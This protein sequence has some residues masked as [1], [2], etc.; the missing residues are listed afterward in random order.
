MRWVRRIW[1]EQPFPAPSASDN[2]GPRPAHYQFVPGPCGA[3][4]APEQSLQCRPAGC[5][6]NLYK[7]YAEAVKLF[8]M[9]RVRTERWRV[10]R[11]HDELRASDERLSR[12]L[13]DRPVQSASQYAQSACSD[14]ARRP[15]N[16]VS[17]AVAEDLALFGVH[18][19]VR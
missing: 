8:S 19:T 9:L 14:G 4:A 2:S 11:V 6:R 18:V 15:L 10:A 13:G 16:A 3:R 1:L 17:R 5:L 7:I 12:S